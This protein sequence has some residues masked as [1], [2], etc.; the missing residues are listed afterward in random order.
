[1]FRLERGGHGVR[2]VVVYVL[3]SR[4]GREAEVRGL[5]QSGVRVRNRVQ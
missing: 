4:G 5:E 3:S 2:D 1:M